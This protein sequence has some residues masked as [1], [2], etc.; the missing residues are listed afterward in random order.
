MSLPTLRTRLSLLSLA[1]LAGCASQS[2]KPAAPALADGARAEVAILETT[3]IHSNVLSYDYYKQKADPTVGLERTA[4]LI[5]QARQ[6]FPNSFL[7]DD[8]DTIQGSVLADYQALVKPL[9]C[10]RELDIYRAMDAIG[11][12]G[13]TAGNH[14][15]NYG[16]GFLSQ[17]SGNPMNVE[18]GTRARCA[19]PHYP[20][21]LANV[22]S[23]RDDQPIFQPWTVV[24]KN[25]EV[26]TVDGSRRQVPLRIGIIGFAPPPI[27][28]W[29][30]HNLQGKVVV[31]GVVEAAQKYLPAL[32]AQ[33]PDLIVA[34][35][36]GGLDSAPYT[37]TME[38]AG[39]YLAGV[40]GID[41]LLLGH[42]HSEFP[43]P[44]YAGLS[45]VDA[46]RG[47]VRGK[48]AVM[49]G[50]FGKD[51]G[52]IELALSHQGGR[53]IIDPEHTRSQVRPICAKPVA[54]Q[55]PACVPADPAIAPLL[56]DTQAAAVAYVNTPIG[57]SQLR[58][59]SYFSDVGDASALA[60]V[61]A[62]QRDYVLA[63]LPR[64]HPELAGVPV[65]SAVAA[66]RTGF[67][68]A[69]DYTD[70]GPGDLTLRSAAD[71]Y[72]YPNTLAAVKIDGA[73]LKG[74]LEHA[75]Q[76]YN[77]IDPSKRD[78]QVLINAAYSGFNADQIQGGIRYQIDLTR[79]V[80]QR[81]VGLSYQ[82]KPVTPQQAFVV[83]TNNYRAG[84][85]GNF[86]GL[87]GDNIVLSAPEGTR[88]LLAQW[89]QR[90]PQLSASDLEPAA[91]RFV[92]LKT[93]GPVLFTSAAGK[94]AVARQAG[95][96]NVR[97]LK[98]NGDGTASYLI[99]LNQ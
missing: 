50:F 92:P 74:W 31:D 56:A 96:N 93:A 95:L 86:P 39:W 37:A 35:L 23:T 72:F 82:G 80:G 90:H 66:F 18:G 22:R 9:G 36:H 21:V 38:N 26:Y 63:E 48:P 27:M 1:L 17:V 13:G 67:G 99:D 44:R 91:W 46:V 87:G 32:Q 64:Q 40:P 55:A 65:L 25:I 88:E 79:P 8:G 51:L 73:T 77:R 85:G 59:S 57:H 30:K 2:S 43:G 84:G 33:H 10:D 71:L 3:D 78:A 54:G 75:A 4:T 15:F 11:Y 68:G 53:W 89:L 81:I 70:V 19:G 28:D 49:G 97:Q 83:V 41:V 98:D 47:T 60:V 62:A 69:D 24:Q 76:R 58:M 14:E 94:Q 16:L 20:L 29:D 61:N 42:A 6:E 34:L 52:V 7:F 45:E 12:D 5:R